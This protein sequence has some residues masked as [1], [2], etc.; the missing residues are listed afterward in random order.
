MLHQLHH[1]QVAMGMT[2]AV[3]AAALEPAVAAGTTQI[4]PSVRHGNAVTS[5]TLLPTHASVDI[6]LAI[7]AS[8]RPCPA[9]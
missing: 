6:S 1:H 5:S 8:R 2:H 9:P 3:A 4:P 7:T